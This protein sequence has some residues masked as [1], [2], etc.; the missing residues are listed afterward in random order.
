MDLTFRTENGRFNHRVGAIIIQDGKIL[1]VKNENAPYYYSVGGR[2]KFGESC[3]EAILRE[4]EEELGIVAT[5]ERPV[6]FNENFFTEVTNG[7]KYHEVSVY[8]LLTLPEASAPLDCQS[9]TEIGSKETLHWL[10]I[11]KLKEV[12]AY[13]LF[14]AEEL[15]DLP[16]GMKYLV[17]RQ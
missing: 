4:V 9:V 8:F 6:F 12:Q 16:V 17:E 3:E 11:A 1:M 14:F 5:V 15:V 10:E 2:V 7:E 13:P